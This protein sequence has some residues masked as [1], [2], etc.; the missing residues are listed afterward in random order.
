[1]PPNMICFLL[2]HETGNRLAEKPAPAGFLIQLRA[3][4]LRQRLPVAGIAK[5]LEIP[6]LNVAVN[7]GF[8][9]LSNIFVLVFSN[10]HA[11][12]GEII[13]TPAWYCVSCTRHHRSRGTGSLPRVTRAREKHGVVIASIHAAYSLR[14]LEMSPLGI[15]HS[16]K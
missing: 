8:T 12:Q 2:T 6:I 11:L 3:P 7:G 15:I 13:H 14:Q 9:E 10:I 4:W 16:R 1:M 5:T